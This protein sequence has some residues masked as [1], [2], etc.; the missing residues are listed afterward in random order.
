MAE[1][2]AGDVPTPEAATAADPAPS[3]EGTQTA[4]TSLTSPRPSAANSRPDFAHRCF[5]GGISW[6]TTE[7]NLVEYFSQF[8]E[9]VSAQLIINRCVVVMTP[10]P[11]PIPS[12]L[13][14]LP[15]LSLLPAASTRR[16]GALASLP[17]GT[18]RPSR[19]SSPTP[20]LT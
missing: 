16:P 8:G 2:E 10:L 11:P 17:S 7:S 1:S 4:H 5:V 18:L 12:P 13:T 3:A 14:A 6:R 20:H 19:P 15:S 9:V